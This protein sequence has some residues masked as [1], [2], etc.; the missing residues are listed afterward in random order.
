[1]RTQQWWSRQWWSSGSAAST[2]SIRYWGHGERG[3]AP[4]LFVHGYCGSERVWAPLRAALASAGFNCLI[5]LCYNAVT[6]DVREVADRLV[7]ESRRALHATGAGKVH[8][9]GHSLGGLVVRE[10]VQR[11]GLAGLT[12]TA[13][14]IATPHG[15]TWLARF[16]LGP[17]AR[18]MRPGSDFLNELGGA[19]LSAGPRWVVL[20]GGADRVVPARSAIP[21]GADTRV[22][23][24]R[25][26]GA[27]HRS[28]TRHGEVV[29]S[30]VTELL[31][32]DRPA[33]ALMAA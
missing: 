25:T 13:V 31:N 10:A 18:Q 17:C 28:I 27:G 12:G 1:M 19:A 11:R 2:R 30:I 24:L 26:A 6:S 22:V 32:A 4:V 7:D 14:T 33:P 15:G 29:R 3:L 21:D 9:V 23:T 5:S 20:H 8:L 16:G